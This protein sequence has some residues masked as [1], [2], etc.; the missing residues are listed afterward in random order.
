MLAEVHRADAGSV[1]LGD[2]G[3]I[4]EG[5]R[6]PT[7][8]DGSVGRPSSCQRRNPEPH[9]VDQQNRR[10]ATKQIHPDR[11]QQ[12][13]RKQRR[14][15][16][17]PDQRDPQGNDQ[18]RDLD[19]HEDLD[20][21]PE[22]SRTSGNAILEFTPGEKGFRA[23]LAS[24]GWSGRAP[25]GR[26]GRPRSKRRRD[27]L[28]A[29]R[30]SAPGG[31]PSRRRSLMTADSAKQPRILTP[32]GDGAAVVER[33]SAARWL[34]AI[35]SAGRLAHPALGDRFEFAHF[36]SASIAYETQAGQRRALAQQ[37]APFFAGGGAELAD[38]G[39]LTWAA[40]R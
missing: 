1:D 27:R 2:V 6:D 12:P 40:V 18:N 3:A 11:R 8:H 24:P 30:L 21:E 9:Q 7:E 29:A 32:T 26:R 36:S 4:G 10:H 23:P 14:R 13:D 35:G 16:A 25:R 22:A 33:L 37:R 20:V 17:R 19:D 31:L 15:P 28:P 34:S 5:E 38:D 39:R